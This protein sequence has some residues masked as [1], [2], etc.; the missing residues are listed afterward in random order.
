MKLDEIYFIPFGKERTTATFIPKI[1]ESSIPKYS[2][3][4][5]PIKTL[6]AKLNYGL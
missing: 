4:A 2:R 1:K 3:Y 5:K 6:K